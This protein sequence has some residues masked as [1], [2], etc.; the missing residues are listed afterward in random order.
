[1]TAQSDRI[2]ATVQEA[3]AAL[4][5]DRLGTCYF[6]AA[7]V[8]VATAFG[9]GTFTDHEWRSGEGPRP[10]VERKASA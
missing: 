6:R 1:M 5:N 4:A 7:G 10:S 2:F 8:F 9:R 3:K